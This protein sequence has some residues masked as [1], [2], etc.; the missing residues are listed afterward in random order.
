MRHHLHGSDADSTKND[1]QF[2]KSEMERQYELKK[3]FVTLLKDLKHFDVN[4]GGD[5]NDRTELIFIKNLDKNHDAIE[6]E[7]KVISKFKVIS[8]FSDD[9]VSCK[10]A[11]ELGRS[12]GFGFV[13]FKT[14]EA[15]RV[16]SKINDVANTLEFEI[17]K[18]KGILLLKL[19]AAR[20][21]Q[22]ELDDRE[23]LLMCKDIATS[24]TFIL[25]TD[26]LGNLP[27]YKLKRLWEFVRGEQLEHHVKFEATFRDVGGDGKEKTEEREKYGVMIIEHMLQVGLTHKRLK[28]KDIDKIRKSV[29]TGEG[30]EEGKKE[31]ED[32]MEEGSEAPGGPIAGVWVAG[33]NFGDSLASYAGG[34]GGGQ[35]GAGGGARPGPGGAERVSM[36]KRVKDK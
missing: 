3:L 14:A 35:G 9:N 20:K 5:Q 15:T 1:L 2:I 26:E 7:E 10:V 29:K 30:M 24:S 36:P 23:F 28:Q 34:G 18:R 8:T 31:E 22:M 19:Y 27:D 21:K 16:K 11:Q 33:D 13:Q 17:D 4:G 25:D 32:E 6:F 12:L